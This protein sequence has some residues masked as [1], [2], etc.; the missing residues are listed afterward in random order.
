MPFSWT[1]P[2]ASKQGAEP[3]LAGSAGSREHLVCKG[4]YQVLEK[5]FLEPKPEVLNMGPLCGDTVAY[6]GGKGSR[7]HLGEFTPPRPMPARVSGK[8]SPTPAPVSLTYDDQ[9]FDLVLA[10]DLVDFVPPE[11]LPAFGAELCRILNPG[12]R[13]FLFSQANQARTSPGPAKKEI[14]D[15]PGRFRILDPSHVRIEKEDGG[16]RSRRWIHPNRDIERALKGLSVQGIHLLR[17][18][19]R[20]FT[21]IRT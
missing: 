6:L 16:A 19:L 1:R 20:E 17:N 9:S 11:C 21:A 13:L 5:V 8:P 3:P 7:V 4:L 12:G 14:Y 15:S 10:W 18:Q 2:G